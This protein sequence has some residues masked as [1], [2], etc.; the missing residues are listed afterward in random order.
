MQV[1]LVILTV[2][3][4]AAYLLRNVRSG[5]GQNQGKCNKCGN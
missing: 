2:I 1:I 3:G 4:A 5:F